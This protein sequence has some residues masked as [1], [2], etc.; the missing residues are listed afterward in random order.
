MMESFSETSLIW[1]LIWVHFALLFIP[2]VALITEIEWSEWK[3][4][5]PGA[6]FHFHRPHFL[7]LRK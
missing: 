2:L 4:R 6:G 1:A 7:H 5:H 3:E